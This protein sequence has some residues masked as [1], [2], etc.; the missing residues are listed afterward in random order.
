MDDTEASRYSRK[1]TLETAGYDVVEASSGQAAL[2]AFAEHDPALVILDIMLPDID[3][4]AVCR[5]IKAADPSA[6]VLHIS[7]VAVASEDR[8]RGLDSGAD[9]YLIDPV[10]PEELLANVQALLRLKAV[11]TELAIRNREADEAQ[12]AREAGEQLLR[13]A[14]EAG[15]MGYWGLDVRTWTLQVSDLLKATFGRKASAQ[16]TFD[17]LRAAIHPED[18]SARDKAIARAMETGEPYCSEF[19]IHWPDGSEHWLEVRGQA[20]READGQ[21][22]RLVG[23]SLDITDRKHREEGRELL[24]QELS[25]RVKNTLTLVLAVA[26][27]TAGHATSLQDYHASLVARVSAMADTHWLLTASLNG[28]V[29][30]GSIFKSQLAPFDGDIKRIHLDGPPVSL[31]AGVA[32]P[33]SMAIHELTTNAVKYGALSVPTAKLTVSW[34]VAPGAFLHLEWIE[35]GG[36]PVQAKRKAGF[37]T[38]LLEHGLKHHAGAKLQM[39][40]RP[41]GLRCAMV[42]PLRSTS[43][44]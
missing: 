22:R 42:I 38:R 2:D 8:I 32:V 41:E 11:S 25:H 3:G 24:V 9:G 40:Y 1:R 5:Q 18:R 7:A 43:A 36:P 14:A 29:T 15:G 23:V 35:E 19:R 28:E 34:D 17:D 16:F 31:P 20:H 33:V 44:A 21:A 13:L 37:G 4:V 27:A 30:L 12:N 26:N 10:H 6:L 39:D